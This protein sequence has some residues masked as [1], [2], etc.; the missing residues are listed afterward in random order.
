MML[1]RRR[2]G[3]IGSCVCVSTTDS[4]RCIQEVP[5]VSK[6]TFLHN[7]IFIIVDVIVYF[8][9]HHHKSLGAS[10]YHE[11]CPQMVRNDVMFSKSER[12][13]F[14]RITR[15]RVDDINDSNLFST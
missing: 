12:H 10:C 1:R 9:V 13:F 4:K 6:A 14:P 5:S 3:R 15:M 8:K 2:R 11:N 7:I